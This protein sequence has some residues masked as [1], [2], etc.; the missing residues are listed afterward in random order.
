MTQTFDQALLKVWFSQGHTSRNFSKVVKMEWKSCDALL[1]ENIAG[2]VY[3]LNW[4]NISM[5]EEIH[6]E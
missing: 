3:I 1:I 6:D 2:A 4:G 5:I